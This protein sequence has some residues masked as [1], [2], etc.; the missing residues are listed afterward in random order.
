MAAAF[1][2]EAAGAVAQVP[3]ENFAA[4]VEAAFVACRVVPADFAAFAHVAQA[5]LLVRE[6]VGEG[7]GG[8]VSRAEDVGLAEGHAEF[9]A[10]DAGAVLPS[11]V[12]LFH[13]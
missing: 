3:H 10:A 11:V 2:K 7:G 4:E 12:L 5:A 9:D 1:V 8:G 6:D 13:E